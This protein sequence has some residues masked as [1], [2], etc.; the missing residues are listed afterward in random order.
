VGSPFFTQEIINSSWRKNIPSLKGAILKRIEKTICLLAA[1]IIAFSAASCSDTDAKADSVVMTDSSGELY[2]S[3][4]PT[5]K[6]FMRKAK[7]ATRS[8]EQRSGL[9]GLIQRTI[10]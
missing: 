9:S 6:R 1:I 10:R 5:I 3:I 8:K 2:A 4:R 7:S